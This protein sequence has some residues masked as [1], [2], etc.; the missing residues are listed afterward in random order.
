M[1]ANS[2][3]IKKCGIY[4]I[5]NIVNNKVYI[6]KSKNIYNRIID[7][8]H[9]LKIKHEDEN[10]YLTNSWH[11]YGRKSFEYF[12]IEY[13]ELNEELVDKRELYWMKIF[14][15]LNR[16]C[17]YNLRSDSQTNMIVHKETSKKISKR[18]KKEWSEGIRSNHG[19]KLSDNWKNNPER[20]I[21]QSAIMTKNLTKYSYR[22]YDLSKVFIETAN[23]KRL[24][25]LGLKNVNATF[26]KKQISYVKFKH[27]FIEKVSN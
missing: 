12:V 9:K 21:I 1:I 18:L 6:G 16:N 14:K 17:G 25:E 11:K 20:R 2:Q 13:L 5:R 15:S 27:F 23:Y 3:D 26:H 8:C 19:Q 7:H 22:L 10:S 24:V 4:C